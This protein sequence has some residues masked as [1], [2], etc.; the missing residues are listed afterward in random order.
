MGYLK[1]FYCNILPDFESSYNKFYI[2]TITFT[3]DCN[4]IMFVLGER[5]YKCE[6]CGKGFTQKQNLKVHERV[7]TGEKPY[8]CDSCGFGFKDLG[9]FFIPPLVSFT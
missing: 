1:I 4:V 3:F 5:P 6:S 7:H 8:I 9:L 2:N